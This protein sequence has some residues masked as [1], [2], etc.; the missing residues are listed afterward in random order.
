MQSEW[1]IDDTVV[2]AV[3]H[4]YTAPAKQNG[5]SVRETLYVANAV[6][7]VYGVSNGTGMNYT[8]MHLELLAALGRLG[9]DQRAVERLLDLA[10]SEVDNIEEFLGE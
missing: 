8:H 5:R 4:Q 3:K 6:C 2:Q 10:E 1:D 9:Y 7:L